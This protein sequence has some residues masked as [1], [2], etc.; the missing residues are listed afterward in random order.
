[1]ATGIISLAAAGVVV[2]GSF[3]T[4][5]Q[6][7]TSCGT[8]HVIYV[9]AD[10]WQLGVP[11]GSGWYDSIELA[12][13]TLRIALC[14]TN[15]GAAILALVGVN[16]LGLRMLRWFDRWRW[17]PPT[18]GTLLIVIGASAVNAPSTL[19]IGKAV[20]GAGAAV[21]AVASIA[22]LTSMRLRSHRGDPEMAETEDLSRHAV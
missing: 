18:V 16:E 21:G 20:C 15:G 19:P 6:G 13:S 1:M 3:L 11:I 14:L 7:G 12:P 17:A 5:I 10:L 2:L 9:R 22:I 4:W 8:L